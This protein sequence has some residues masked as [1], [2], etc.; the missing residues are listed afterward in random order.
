M[1]ILNVLEEQIHLVNAT[2]RNF[3]TNVIVCGLHDGVIRLTIF[4]LLRR[5]ENLT[6]LRNADPVFRKCQNNFTFSTIPRQPHV[7]I[8]R[9]FWR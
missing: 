2:I 3:A 6:F 4:E 1:D 5:G 8:T 9:S 7:G